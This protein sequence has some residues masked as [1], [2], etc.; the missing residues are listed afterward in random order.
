MEF[1]KYSTT[2]GEVILYTGEPNK[3][4][5]EELSAGAGDIWHSSLDQGYKNTFQDLVYFAATFW[6]HFNDYDGLDSCLSWRVNPN[7]F[8]IRE[9]IWK[10]IHGFDEDYSTNHMKGLDFGFKALKNSG[11]VVLYQK[12]L[13]EAKKNKIKI[14]RRD[15]YLFYKKNLKY[16][17]ALYMLFR[18]GFW[19]FSEWKQY[20]WANTN[21]IKASQRLIQNKEL[22]QIQ[23]KPSISYII[24]TMMR[25]DYTAQLLDDL[26]HQ[27]YLPNQVVIVDATP[28]KQRGKDI[29]NFSKYPFEVTLKWQASKGSCRARNEA[30]ELCYGDYIVFGD[31]DIRLQP[32][33]IENHIRFLQTYKVSACNGLDIMADHYQQNLD[34]LQYKILKLDEHRKRVSVSQNFNNANSCV[35]KDFVNQLVGNDINFDG[36]YGEDADFGQRLFKTGITV[37]YNPFSINLHLKPPSGGYRFWGMQ[38]KILGKNR[39][40]QPWEL[41][42]PVKYIRPVP[43]PTKMYQFLKHFTERQNIE[44]KYKYML[45]YLTKNRKSTFVFRITNLP[46]KLMQFRKSKYYAKRLI[47][48]GPRYK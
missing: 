26:K 4:L 34:D 17:H 46:Y 1:N 45:F 44:F 14:N 18:K 33:F 47:N 43:S 27:T 8:A 41:G 23:G 40:Q 28:K 7:S 15:R 30:I 25:Q 3:T 22:N 5:L 32:N 13:F 16:S 11:A 29:Y 42:I 10:Q 12:D 19:K 2:S 20:L 35:R 31:D 39:K 38:A 48:I 6:W 36:G 24:P 21:A 37:M 9:S